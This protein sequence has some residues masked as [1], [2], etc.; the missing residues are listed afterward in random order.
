[1]LSR[2]PEMA[3]VLRS[4][5]VAEKKAAL[6]WDSVVA[7]IISSHSGSLSASKL[8]E[9]LLHKEGKLKR[10]IF[11]CKKLGYFLLIHYLT[12]ETCLHC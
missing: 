10:P 4:L 5:F 8:K 7:K 11:T 1:M 2:L 9:R 6:P 3:R 12:Q